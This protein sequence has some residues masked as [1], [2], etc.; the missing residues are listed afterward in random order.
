M[1]RPI[2]EAEIEQ[3]KGQ[4]W[5]TKFLSRWRV[6]LKDL[7]ARNGRG[8]SDWSIVDGIR[9]VMLG[10]TPEKEMPPLPTPPPGL[11]KHEPKPMQGL[12]I[13][14]PTVY[15]AERKAAALPFSR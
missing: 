5:R 6:C 9:P 12:R 3:A 15:S 14:P 7:E 13:E 1:R 11:P 10:T 4:H 2:T 8:E